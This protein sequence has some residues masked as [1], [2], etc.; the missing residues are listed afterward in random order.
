MKI[1]HFVPIGQQT[2]PPHAILVSDLLISKKSFPLKLL[3][4]MIQ[5]W[6]EASTC[7]EG[8]VLNF[9]KSRMKGEQHRLIPL[10]LQLVHRQE[11]ESELLEYP[12]CT[13]PY[14]GSSFKSKFFKLYYMFYITWQHDLSRGV[15]RGAHVSASDRQQVTITNNSCFIYF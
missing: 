1:A 7:M 10:S 4:Q 11:I 2:W 14:C 8:S 3:S 9:L 6:Q 12:T 15:C 5:T 13:Y